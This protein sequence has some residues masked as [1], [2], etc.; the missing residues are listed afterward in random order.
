[1]T[2]SSEKARKLIVVEIIRSAHYGGVENHVFAILKSMDLKKYRPI[3]ISLT[4]EPVNPQ[5]AE[6][7]IEIVSLQDRV[8]SSYRSFLT[9]LPLMRTLRKIRPDIVHLH[10]IRP[11]FIGSLAAKM[12]GVKVII[13]TLHGPHREM[14]IQPSGEVNPFLLAASKVMHLVGFSLSTRIITISDFGRE[15]VRGL[16]RLIPFYRQEALTLRMQKIY[17][18]IDVK[19]YDDLGNRRLIREK[20]GLAV[21]SFIFGT[22]SRLD[23][24][25]KGLSV[26]LHAASMLVRDG[27]PAFFLITGQGPAMT[28][29]VRLSNELGLQGRVFFLGYWNDVREV[30]GTLDVFVLPSLTEGFGIVN[31]EAMAARLPIVGTAVG[32]VPEAVVQY[33]NGVLV[34]PN[35]ARQLARAM[36]FFMDFPEIGQKMGHFG[37]KRVE[38]EFEVALMTEKVLSMYEATRIEKNA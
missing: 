36:S 31:L 18:G 13:S 32:G 20:L 29:L 37:R 4:N 7:G 25:K 12:A 11:I 9:L 35:D 34:S 6:L 21:D 23:E 27:H 38:S 10:G 30:L 16:F 5:F 26:F 19:H 22:I 28:Q 24:P 14:A 8:G 33:H 3:L 2:G 15:D 17:N 1:M